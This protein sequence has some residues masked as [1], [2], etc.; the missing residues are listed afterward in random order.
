MRMDKSPTPTDPALRSTLTPTRFRLNAWAGQRDNHGQFYYQTCW[1]Q[2]PL[3]VTGIRR[4]E[5]KKCPEKHTFS[6][7]SGNP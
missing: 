5:M 3:S 7:L 4:Q 1:R 2:P 6:W